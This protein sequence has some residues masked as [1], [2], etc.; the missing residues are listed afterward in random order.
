[1]LDVMRSNARSSLIVLIFG[2]I[3]VTF[4]FSFGRG[5]SGFRTRTAETWAARVNGDLITAG[6]FSRAY[7]QRFRQMSVQRGG[8]Y[9][10]DDAKQD[11]LRRLT[12]R[13]LVDQEL[14]VQQA[15]DLG[16]VVSDQELGDSIASSPEFQRNGRFDYQYY[17]QYVENGYRRTVPSFESAWRRDL[18]TRKALQAVL[19]GAQA[20]TD[21]VRAWYVA[22]HE[23]ASIG[24][25]RFSPFVFRDK[26]QATDAEIAEYDKT[27]GKEIE[28]A[29]QRDEKTRWTQPPSVKV[30]AISTLVPPGSTPQQEQAARGR[31]DAALAE[32]KAGKDFAQVAK[33]KSEDPSTKESGG[34]LGFVSR[35]GSAYGRTLEDEATKLEP[36]QMSGVFKDRSGFHVLKAEEKKPGRTQPVSEVR[37]QIA[38]DLVRAQKSTELA[39]QKAQEALAAVRAGKDLKDLFPVKKSEPGQFDF[40]SLTTPQYSET[41]P[42]H[43]VGGYVPNLGL[44]PKLSAAAFALTT[45]GATPDAP[46]Q[47]GDNWYVFRLKSRERADLSKLDDTERKSLRDRIERQR[48]D[49]LYQSWIERLRKNSKIVENIAL[50][51]YEAQTGHETFNPDD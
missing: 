8:K 3:I 29:Y 23:S 40:A 46:V 22:Q 33:E 2:A 28:E 10:V 17:R 13:S 50:L 27:H 51:D 26:A 18:L 21:D 43:P 5:S 45:P 47:D 35:G 11:D 36:G 39:R 44:A 1:M 16:I 20:S 32:V 12:L 7:D 31:I 25:V 48:Q 41:E 14:I 42:F 19:T 34:E 6:D 24:Y 37:K 15:K 30:R 38:Q 4:I 49:E 9:T